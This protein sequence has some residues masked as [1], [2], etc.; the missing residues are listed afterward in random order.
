[1]TYVGG[2]PLQIRYRNFEIWLP[3]G[4]QF[5]YDELPLL[6]AARTAEA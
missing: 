1:V 6:S 5:I 4:L 2:L 3:K